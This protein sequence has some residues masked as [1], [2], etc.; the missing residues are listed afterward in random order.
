MAG[1]GRAYDSAQASHR[2]LRG[3]QR[4]L[5]RHPAVT[6]VRGFP[7]GEYTSVVADIA[8]DR[9]ELDVNEA[10]LTVRWFAGE[11]NTDRPA[12]SFHYSDATGDFGW[13]HHPQEHVDGWGHFQERADPER[14][15][16]YESYEFSST[17]PTRVVWEV[18]AQVTSKLESE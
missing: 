8:V 18:M 1:N 9:I 17:N 4:E 7:S 2:A 14:T 16:T 11:S 12:F 15:Y 5:E 10:T 3:I 6:A 13:H